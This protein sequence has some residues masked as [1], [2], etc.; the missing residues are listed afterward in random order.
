MNYKMKVFTE[1]LDILPDGTITRL[2]LNTEPMTVTISRNEPDQDFMI[3][4]IDVVDQERLE[5]ALR[6]LA[7]HLHDYCIFS[8]N[9]DCV[10]G[11]KTTLKI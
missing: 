2:K 9:L 10:D 7:A 1:I 5:E 11:S 4:K 6:A 8:I 3:E